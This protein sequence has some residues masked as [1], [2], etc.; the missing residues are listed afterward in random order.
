MH[1]NKSGVYLFSSLET[2]TAYTNTKEF[3]LVPLKHPLHTHAQKNFSI[4]DFFSKCDQIRSFQWNFLWTGAS[5]G[6]TLKM[7]ARSP[8]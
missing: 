5:D 3:Y 2:Y 8:I 1:W 6:N 4:K 7:K